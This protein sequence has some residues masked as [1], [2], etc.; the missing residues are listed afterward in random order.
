MTSNCD[1][2]PASTPTDQVFQNA[3]LLTSSIGFD[4]IEIFNETAYF[5]GAHLSGTQ[6]S[7]QNKSFDLT[8]ACYYFDAAKKTMSPA[9]AVKLPLSL[10][11]GFRVPLAMTLLTMTMVGLM[12]M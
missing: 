10:A 11:A 1:L 7:E 3:T 4:A 12:L 5:L 2:A 9:A 8:T 6:H